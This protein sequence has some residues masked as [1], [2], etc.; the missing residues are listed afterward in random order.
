MTEPRRDDALLWLD[1]ETTGLNSNTDFLLEVGLRL[2]DLDGN[3]LA[4]TDVQINYPQLQQI[5][6]TTIDVVKSMHEK[7][8]LWEECRHGL[9]LHTAT[10]VLCNWVN[11][12]NAWG[13]PLMGSSV[14]FDR[15]FVN[16]K[17]ASL[18]VMFHYRNIN[19][20][21]IKELC[22]RLNPDLF[23]Q[24]ENLAETHRVR[25]CLDWSVYQYKFYKTNFFKVRY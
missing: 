14:D 11:D 25:D 1:V 4:E 17:M 21:S 16:K 2:T 23:S 24:M 8:G 10:N 6:S 19:I 18:G 9:S 12:N 20:S 5:K 15:G 22:R 3:T 13:M 7:N